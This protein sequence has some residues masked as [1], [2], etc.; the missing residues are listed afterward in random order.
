MQLSHQFIGGAAGIKILLELL[1]TPILK[2]RH[3][4]G[5][6]VSDGQGKAY[7]SKVAVHGVEFLV[8]NAGQKCHNVELAGQ[9]HNNR[10]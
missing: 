7:P 3:K 8:P 9:S 1:Q 10:G 6:S 2:R 4:K 5:D